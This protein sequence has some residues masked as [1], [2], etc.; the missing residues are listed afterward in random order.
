MTVTDRP[1][2]YYKLNTWSA[3]KDPTQVIKNRPAYIYKYVLIYIYII[4]VSG[5]D[6]TCLQTALATPPHSQTTQ[7][8]GLVPTP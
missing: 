4:L 1:T 5:V 3:G 2:A 7:F 6:L 8:S